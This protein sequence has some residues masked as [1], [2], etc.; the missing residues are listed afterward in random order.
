MNPPTITLRD[1]FA[2]QAL[3]AVAAP[4]AQQ[5][6]LEPDELL[7]MTPAQQAQRYAEDCYT[8]ADA[9]MAARVKEQ[10]NA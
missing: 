5:S 1:Y 7:M 10:T 6:D 8:V 9:M 2:G 4:L 3:A